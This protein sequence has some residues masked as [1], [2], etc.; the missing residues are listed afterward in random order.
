LSYGDGN[1]VILW[2]IMR[3]FQFAETWAVMIIMVVTVTRIVVI[4]AWI[5]KSL[6]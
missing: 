5:R 6:I 3:A 1:G 2:N 4:L